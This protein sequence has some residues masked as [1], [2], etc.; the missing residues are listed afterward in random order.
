VQLLSNEDVI[1][2]I[3]NILG[4]ENFEEYQK[5]LEIDGSYS[6][7]NIARYRINCYKDSNGNSIAFRSIPE[8]IPSMESL[9]LGEQMKTM[10]Q[11]SK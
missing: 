2:I 4:E 8:D 7:K 11:K 10:C 1:S 9:G 5:N 6:H 3:K